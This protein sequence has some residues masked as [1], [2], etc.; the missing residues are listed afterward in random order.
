MYG[1]SGMAK[2][3]LIC[4]KIGCGK[5][6]YAA[7]LARESGAL[8]LSFDEIMLSLCGQNFKEAHDRYAE[9]IRRYLFRQSVEL[10]RHGVDMILDWGFWTRQSREEA[11]AFYRARGVAWELHSIEISDRA[12]AARLERRNHAVAAG[13]S[14]AYFVDERLAQKCASRFAPPERDEMDVWITVS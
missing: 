10:V 7:Q 4:G 12:W 9:G 14:Q 1:G 11:K 8:V 2:A 13:E 5:S 3:I 6:T